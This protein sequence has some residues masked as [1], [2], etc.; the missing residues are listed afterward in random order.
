MKIKRTSFCLA[1]LLCVASVANATIWYA[2]NSTVNIDSANEWNDAAN[3]SGSYLTWASRA[4][5]IR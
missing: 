4:A 3:G 2:Q 1:L 5:A